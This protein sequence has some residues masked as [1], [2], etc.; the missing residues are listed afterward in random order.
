M[1]FRLRELLRAFRLDV[2]LRQKLLISYLAIIIVPFVILAI[3]A[4]LVFVKGLGLPIPVCPA[5]LDDWCRGVHI[6]N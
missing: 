5:V 2:K 4:V 6:G 3:F 1:R